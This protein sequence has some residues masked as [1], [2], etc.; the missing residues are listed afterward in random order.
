LDA[1]RRLVDERARIENALKTVGAQEARGLVPMV[2]NLVKHASANRSTER[3]L[4]EILQPDEGES[5]A[6]AAAR[7]VERTQVLATELS[8]SS[9]NAS[10]LRTE[11]DAL[12]VQI[13]ETAK[14]IAQVSSAME[15]ASNESLVASARQLAERAKDAEILK[16]R[17]SKLRSE[18]KEICAENATLT[19]QVGALKD[20]LGSEQEKVHRLEE[21]IAPLRRLRER[22]QELRSQLIKS[23]LAQKF[24]VGLKSLLCE[25]GKLVGIPFA[26]HDEKKVGREV[27]RES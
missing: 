17:V 22:V 5:L 4:L 24:E 23:P 27:E 10:V 9:H 25:V 26:S 1:T 13:G 12:K 18:G 3:N 16:K 2:E 11:R 14:V 21:E 19:R 8:A 15:P 7:V 6:D 20:Q